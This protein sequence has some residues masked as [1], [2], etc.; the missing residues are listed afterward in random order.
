M[1]NKETHRSETV[2]E[3]EIKLIGKASIRTDD[4]GVAKHVLTCITVGFC[5]WVI[6]A[7]TSVMCVG[8]VF[9]GAGLRAAVSSRLRLL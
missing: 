8:T 5:C 6:I 9:G 3:I 4:S 1:G 7:K 2:V